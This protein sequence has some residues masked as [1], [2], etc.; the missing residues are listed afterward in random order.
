MQTNPTA[1]IGRDD[2]VPPSVIS[3]HSTAPIDQVE[4]IQKNPKVPDDCGTATAP[5]R[6]TPREEAGWMKSSTIVDNKVEDIKYQNPNT[7]QTKNATLTQCG[8]A[9]F[10]DDRK[11]VR[12]RCARSRPPAGAKPSN[13]TSA[14]LISTPLGTRIEPISTAN[15][16]ES[17]ARTILDGNRNTSLV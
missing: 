7:I 6:F 2:V 9:R 11:R 17:I 1:E 12:A 13:A 14:M 4:I 16:K 15:H 8:L 10:E 5:V 3:A